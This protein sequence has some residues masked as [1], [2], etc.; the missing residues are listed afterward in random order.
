MAA[1]FNQFNEPLFLAANIIDPLN[2]P[3]LEAAEAESLHDYGN[4]EFAFIY[5][6]FS[7]LIGD[8]FDNVQAVAEWIELKSI[9]VEMH[10]WRD[11]H[12]LSIYQV[13]RSTQ[14]E[15][16]DIAAALLVVGLVQLFPLATAVVERGFSHLNLY[17]Y[18]HGPFFDCFL[19]VVSSCSS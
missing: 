1:R 15:D 8:K 10:G 5:N 12:P 19:K 3:D 6:H 11:K 13:L 9:V 18:I 2:W 16:I 7:D 14:R 4:D 17:R